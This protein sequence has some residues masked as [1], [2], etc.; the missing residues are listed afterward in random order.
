M[1]YPKNRIEAAYYLAGTGENILDVGCGYGNLLY[2]LKDSFDKL[3]GVE[4]NKTRVE[5]AK[6][7]LKDNNFEIIETTVESANFPDEY[8]DVVVSSDVIEHIIDVFSAF[9]EMARILKKGGKLI[10]ITPNI[11]DIRRRL[12]LLFGKF[13]STSASDEGFGFNDGT[14]IFDGGHVHYFTFSALEK[15]Y[16]RYGIANIKRY[17]FG[18]FGRA[19]NILPS[20]LSPSCAVVGIK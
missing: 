19:H 8:F 10:V 13:P 3:Y 7:L 5:K 17:G 2:K 4:I 14:E 18:R 11:A 20:L 6:E 9:K 16:K 12:T 15:L 1:K